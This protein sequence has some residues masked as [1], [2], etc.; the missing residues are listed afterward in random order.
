M[1]QSDEKRGHRI[2][3]RMTEEEKQL[4]MSFSD[5]MSCS[6]SEFLRGSLKEYP[7]EDQVLVWDDDLRELITVADEMENSHSFILLLRADSQKL[8]EM[9]FESYSAFDGLRIQTDHLIRSVL[10]IREKMK[11][12]V[13]EQLGIAHKRAPVTT[14]YGRGNGRSVCLCVSMNDSEMR[15]LGD[16]TDNLDCSKSRYLVEEALK[17][18]NIGAIYIKAHGTESVCKELEKDIRFQDAVLGEIK[19]CGLKEEELCNYLFLL[20]NRSEMVQDFLSSISDRDK[21]IR[22]EV[23]KILEENKG[24][25]GGWLTLRF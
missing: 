20:K 23:Q 21:D 17:R 12:E 14:Y 18:V 6:I 16:I 2:T 5:E 7:F 9:L 1:S 19:R 15:K 25:A 8:E 24:E 11:K 10:R 3:V 4:I 22:Q 13:A